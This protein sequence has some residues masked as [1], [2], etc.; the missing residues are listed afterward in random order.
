MNVFWKCWLGVNYCQLIIFFYCFTDMYSK[1]LVVQKQF[2]RF[3]SSSQVSV[4]LRPFYFSVHPDLFGRHPLERDTNEN[5]LKQLNSYIDI[6]LHQKPVRPSR[7]KFYLKKQNPQEHH[8]E[9][10]DIS[11]GHK[12]IVGALQS[13]L[14]S[15][16]L[17]TEYVDKLPKPSTPQKQQ[18]RKRNSTNCN[19]Y[20]LN[21]FTF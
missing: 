14:T 10:V 3:L 7:V 2:V 20:I 17:S 16:N 1:S 19:C 12:D 18:I 13:I 5:S 6:L 11:L 21:L 8:F 4:A 15:C 9:T